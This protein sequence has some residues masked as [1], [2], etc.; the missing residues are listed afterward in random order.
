MI[1]EKFMYLL[2]NGLPLNLITTNTPKVVPIHDHDF[3]ELVI[4]QRGSAIHTLY[5]PD[6]GQNRYPVL[7]GDCFSVLPG[8]PHSYENGHSVFYTNLL[9]RMELI[10]P[11]IEKLRGLSAWNAVF[12]SR[13]PSERTKIR[14]NVNERTFADECMKRLA[15]ELTQKRPG[16]EI[17][18]K[19]IFLDILLMILRKEPV[20]TEPA[21]KFLPGEALLEAI[22]AIENAPE[23]EYSLNAL[24]R[25]T[26]MCVLGFTRKF[27]MA[28]GLSPMEYI[29]S[30]RLDNASK[31]LLSTE[32]PLSEIARECGFYDANY[33]VK[34]F[35]RHYGVTPGKFRLGNREKQIEKTTV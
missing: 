17:A 30:L 22:S 29:L 14:L 27:R 5:S 9:F 8:E 2:Q 34:A 23:R 33:L 13:S 28:T 26:F 6:G 4:F 15:Q 21:G 19:A 16:F 25:K 18:A 12:G 31:L 10:A 1:H 24:A 11:E 32:L 3:I 20:R 35:S 7:Q